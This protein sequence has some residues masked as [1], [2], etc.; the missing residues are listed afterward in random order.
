MAFFVKSLLFSMLWRSTSRKTEKL[1]HPSRF[2]WEEVLT[3]VFL[4]TKTNRVFCLSLTRSTS[5]NSDTLLHPIFLP[6]L[7]TERAKAI[8]SKILTKRLPKV[9]HHFFQKL[10]SRN[11]KTAASCLPVQIFLRREICFCL[12]KL[13]N[14]FV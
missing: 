13:M 10:T 3:N 4:F 14:Y 1:L 12:P 9:I 5:G 8:F 7:F 6:F 11:R 2:F